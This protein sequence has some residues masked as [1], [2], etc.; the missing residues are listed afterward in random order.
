MSNRTYRATDYQGGC[1]GASIRFPPAIDWPTNAGTRET[2]ALLEPIKKKYGKGLSY[3]DLIVLAGN[4]AAER[5]G[6]EPMEFCPGRTDAVDGRGWQHLEYGNAEYPDS[7]DKMIEAYERRGQTAQEYVALTLAHYGS[8]KNLQK[9]LESDELP[10]GPLGIFKEGLKYYPELRYWVDYYISS[11]DKA[12]FSDFSKAWTKLM[13]ADRFD[14][15]LG[16]VCD[17]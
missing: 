10:D 16:N 7:V 15:P 12:Y 11:A 8:V 3:A 2:L 9:M 6:A 5:S 14:G 1:N 4:V 13:N 17:K